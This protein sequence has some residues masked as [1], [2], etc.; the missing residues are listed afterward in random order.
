MFVLSA[1]KCSMIKAVCTTEKDDTKVTL[2]F[3]NK[4][5]DD[6]LL[7][8]ELD[9]YARKFPHKF[10]VWY[11]L[12][13]PPVGWQYGS[14]RI[15][16]NVIQERLP[17]PNGEDSKVLVCGPPGMQNAMINT[18]VELGFHRPGAVAHATDEIF[19]F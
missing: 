9:E 3:A 6:I 17:S 18:L 12:D 8:K 16:K 14:G 11:I 10:K 4:T 5:E 19:V 7:R 15:D 13:T 2:L 1:L